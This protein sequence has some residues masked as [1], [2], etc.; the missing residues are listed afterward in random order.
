MTLNY[1]ISEG[2]KKH[3]N[4]CVRFIDSKRID[5]RATTGIRVVPKNWSN[6]KQRIKTNSTSE[7]VDFL[8]DKLNKLE[9]HIFDCYNRDYNS[10][11]FISKTWLKEN[12]NSFFNRVSENESYRTYFVEWVE[13]FVKDASKRTYNGTKLKE[14]SILNYTSTLSKL[15]AFES[16]RK[17]KLRFEDIDLDFHSDFINY[18]IQ[19]EKL[20]KNTVGSIVSRIKTFCRSAESDGLP[21]NPKFK[22]RDFYLPKSKTTNTYLNEDEINK[23]YNHDFSNSARLDNARDLFIIGLRTGLRISDFLR[24]TKENIFGNV[25]NITTIKTHQNLTVPIHPQFEEI[26]KKRNGHLPH[27]IGDQKFNKYIKEVC[28]EVEINALTPG[29][30][31]NEETKRKEFGTYPKHELIQS[32][33]CRRSFCTNLYL[34]GVDVNIIMAASGHTSKQFVNYIKA[35]QDE[36]I[37]KISDSWKKNPLKIEK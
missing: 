16:N 19:E 14:R 2:K 8:N 23:I 11:T 1:Y 20:G 3:S 33:I 18:C 17:K 9:N 26:L 5:Q 15:Q 13:R 32:H 37:K 27:S 6:P 24:I 4:I 25:I 22:H 28:K 7:N 12:V 29:D 21:I 34:A 31:I 30:K 35:T 36:H 10:S